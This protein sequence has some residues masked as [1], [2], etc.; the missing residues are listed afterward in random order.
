MG[1]ENLA[2]KKKRKVAYIKKGLVLISADCS[3]DNFRY[4]ILIE[5]VLP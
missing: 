3:Y 5:I 1:N 4:C 2:F